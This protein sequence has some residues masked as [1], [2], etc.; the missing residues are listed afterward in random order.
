MNA[1]AESAPTQTKAL[2]AALNDGGPN[3]QMKVAVVTVSANSPRKNARSDGRSR[4]DDAG[5]ALD[6]LDA[7]T[8]RSDR[9]R[10]V[11]LAFGVRRDERF[12][13]GRRN[14]QEVDQD[15]PARRAGRRDAEQ[16]RQCRREIDAAR[17]VDARA[18]LDVR[19]S[20][21]DEGRPHLGFLA[22]VAAAV[23][24]PV[25]G[26][27]DDVRTRPSP[28]VRE[29]GSH[30]VGCSS[31]RRVLGRPRAVRVPRVV[32]AAQVNDDQA[33]APLQPRD[34]GNDGRRGHDVRRFEGFREQAPPP[35]HARRNNRGVH[36]GDAYPS[37]DIIDAGRA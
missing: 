3:S 15:A 7:H 11:S 18:G 32:D 26:R 10:H 20:R 14:A 35:V 25:V 1:I 27:H 8:P 16:R 9:G 13:I 28:C 2:R 23:A 22:P 37:G 19:A 12:P 24:M 33:A 21:D 36:P 30:A 4:S 6:G 29:C 31:R 34:L 17:V 5:A